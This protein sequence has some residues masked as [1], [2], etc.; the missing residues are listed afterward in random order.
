MRNYS[1]AIA[2][3]I[4]CLLLQACARPAAAAPV[5]HS[6]VIEGMAY[7]PAVVKVKKGDRITWVNKDFF[8]H[9]VTA[10]N[11]SFDSGEIA[12]GKSWTYTVSARGKQAYVCT[13]HP[14]MKGQI[15]AD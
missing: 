6:V 4:A 7:V 10:A 2:W 9:T 12:T 11:R 15:V 1:A 8:P 5:K 13:L 3:C 14:A